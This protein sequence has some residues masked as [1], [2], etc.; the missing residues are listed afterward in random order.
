[1]ALPQKIAQSLFHDYKNYRM[2]KII[3]FCAASSQGGTHIIF[4]IFTHISIVKQK[5]YFFIVFGATS[6][7]EDINICKKKNLSLMT[8][9]DVAAPVLF[10]KFFSA[11]TSHGVAKI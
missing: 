4:F 9:W 11:V 10:L 1:M 2:K 6:F 3:I 8:A 5:I 7:N